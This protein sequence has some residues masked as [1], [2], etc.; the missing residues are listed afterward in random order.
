MQKSQLLN[1]L[2]LND[3]FELFEETKLENNEI[4][5][6]KIGSAKVIRIKDNNV[7]LEI[8]IPVLKLK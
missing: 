3:V 5:D 1:S 6:K 2:K 7:A 8:I 4:V